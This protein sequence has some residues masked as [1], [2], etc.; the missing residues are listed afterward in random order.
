MAQGNYRPVYPSPDPITTADGTSTAV[1]VGSAKGFWIV[2]DG[3]ARV[4][5]RSTDTPVTL[6]DTNSAALASG[7]LY[8]TFQLMGGPDKFIHVAGVGGTPVATITLV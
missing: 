4:A 1:P 7:M 2:V 8:G 5:V 3:A 6:D